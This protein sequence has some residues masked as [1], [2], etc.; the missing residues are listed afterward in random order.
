M[1]SWPFRSIQAGL[2]HVH[3]WGTRGVQKDFLRRWLCGWAKP[4][5]N[6]I[7][8]CPSNTAEL[9][10]KLSTNAWNRLPIRAPAAPPVQAAAAWLA[11]CTKS[12]FRHCFFR[13]P[14][15]HEACKSSSKSTRCC[16]HPPLCACIV[17]QDTTR[18]V[19]VETTHRQT[20]D[21]CWAF[22]GG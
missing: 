13:C 6:A 1:G 5:A 12:L 18:K 11:A 8:Q 2:A 19:A 15:H 21:L 3:L 16:P 22:F 4:H 7:G 20:V 17:Y 14:A 10:T 9:C